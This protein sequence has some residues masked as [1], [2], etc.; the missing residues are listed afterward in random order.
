MSRERAEGTVSSEPSERESEFRSS[1][2]FL[3]IPDLKNGAT[4][5]TE[6]N[7]EDKTWKRSRKNRGSRNGSAWPRFARSEGRAIGKCKCRSSVPGTCISRLLDPQ[8]TGRKRPVP[9]GPNRASRTSVTFVGSVAPFLR[10]GAFV[11]SPTGS[12]GTRRTRRRVRR[13]EQPP[14]IA[15]HRRVPRSR[16]R[17][18]EPR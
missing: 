3:E 7:G 10:S 17:V 15:E 14:A 6:K 8:D 18:R 4:K 12:A 5:P 2:R 16:R 9:C 1:R 11:I 13:G